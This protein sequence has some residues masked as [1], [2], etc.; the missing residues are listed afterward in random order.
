MRRNSLFLLLIALILT[1]TS[2][3]PAFAADATE[4]KGYS[5]VTKGRTVRGVDIDL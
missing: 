5:K 1:F 4:I 2:V 3:V